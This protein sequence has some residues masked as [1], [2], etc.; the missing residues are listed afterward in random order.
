MLPQEMELV[1]VYKMIETKEIAELSII[2]VLL[3]T[4]ILGFLP[5]IDDTHV[6]IEDNI[7]MTCARLSSTE[8][9]CYPNQ[10]DNVGR[11]LCSGT[12][13][14]IFRE[15]IQIEDQLV[16]I[17]FKAGGTIE[18]PV[19]DGFVDNDCYFA[20]RKAFRSEFE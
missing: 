2:T 6:C 1:V 11:K 18:C 3:I 8:R 16:K 14:F 20:G 7:S 10:N 5:E 12:W 9:T 19:T 15:D 13:K 4:S 17:N